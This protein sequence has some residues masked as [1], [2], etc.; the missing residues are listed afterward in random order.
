MVSGNMHGVLLLAVKSVEKS[1]AIDNPS[2]ALR[3]R[4]TG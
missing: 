4:R 3:M 2:G 1:G